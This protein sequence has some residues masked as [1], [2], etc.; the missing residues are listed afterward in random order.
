M[1]KRNVLLILTFLFV[2]EFGISAQTITKTTSNTDTTITAKDGHLTRILFIFDASKSMWTRW[3]S[4]TKIAIAQRILSNLLDSL[5]SFPELQLGLRVYGHQKNFPPQ[6]CDDSRLE[7]PFAYN[8]IPKIKHRLKLLYPKGTTPIAMSL[9]QCANDFPPCKNCRNIVIL[10]TDGIEECSGDPC[11]IS[12]ELQKKGIILKPFII[13]IGANFKEAFNCVGTYYDATS[14]EEF[15]NILNVV[16]SQALNTTS[17]Q[18]NILDEASKPT[19]T[20]SSMTFYD[21]ISGEVKYNFEHTM[22]T[23]G[24]PDTLYIDPIP[25]YKVKVHTIPPVWSDTISMNIGKHTIIPVSAPQ[26]NMIFKVT[27]KNTQ[28][29]SIPVLIKKAGQIPPINTQY[30]DTPDKYIVG[31]YDAEVICLPRLQIKNIEVKQNHTVTVD[32]PAPGVAEINKGTEGNGS[33]FVIRDNK[34]EWIYNLS[35]NTK[36]ENVLLQP[37]SYKIIFRSRYSN[38]TVDSKEVNFEIKSSIKTVINLL[39]PIK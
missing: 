29:R 3:Q 28:Y 36:K 4:D 21:A 8:N 24:Y 1:K 26:G 34:M 6:D 30:F 13:G 17:C 9:L 22:N 19:E 11:K 27:D 20:N 7:I 33:L 31:K 5:Q 2:F 10:I 12:I 38:Q 32:V 16:I 35:T 25:T 23:H 18:V 14:E 39:D 15:S 37:G